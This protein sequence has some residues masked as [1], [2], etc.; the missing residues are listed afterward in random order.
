MGSSYIIM[1]YRANYIR[2][3]I[4]DHKATCQAEYDLQHADMQTRTEQGEM[5]MYQAFPEWVDVRLDRAT[6]EVRNMI[7]PDPR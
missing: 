5:D 3:I 4:R 1:G 2:P 7:I 6:A